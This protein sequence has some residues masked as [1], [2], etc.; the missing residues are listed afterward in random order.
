VRDKEM[1]NQG[2]IVGSTQNYSKRKKKITWNKSRGNKLKTEVASIQ[3][4]Q[5]AYNSVRLV[6]AGLNL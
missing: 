6:L 3:C 1:A 5:Q 2:D 4:L